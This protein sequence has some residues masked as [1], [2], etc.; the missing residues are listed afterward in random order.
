MLKHLKELFVK[1]SSSNDHTEA[2]SKLEKLSKNLAHKNTI[3]QAQKTSVK[4][5]ESALP[6]RSVLRRAQIDEESRMKLIAKMAGIS[7]N[8]HQVAQNGRSLDSD[9]NFKQWLSGRS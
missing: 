6:E 7:L 5:T 4:T 3:N 1:K 9:S 8:Q 2:L